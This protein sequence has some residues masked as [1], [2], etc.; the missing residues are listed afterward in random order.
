MASE[1]SGGGASERSELT[2]GGLA[3]AAEGSGLRVTHILRVSITISYICCALAMK[4][5]SQIYL[6]TRNPLPS[7]ATARP[8]AVIVTDRTFGSGSVVRPN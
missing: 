4:K 3:V 2:A 1:A 6:T 8:Q 5:M 7:A